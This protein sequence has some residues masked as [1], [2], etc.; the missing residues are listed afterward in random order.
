MSEILTLLYHKESSI[1]YP[2]IVLVGRGKD[3]LLD[4]PYFTIADVEFSEGSA[5][6]MTVRFD[7]IEKVDVKV[8]KGIPEDADIGPNMALACGMIEVGSNGLTIEHE[9][10]PWPEGLTH[11]MVALNCSEIAKK[12]VRTITFYVKH[13]KDKKRNIFSRIFKRGKK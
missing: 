13:F 11:V 2:I 12:E 4:A 7:E 10:I 3:L 6:V 9:K 5:S 1:I 8:F